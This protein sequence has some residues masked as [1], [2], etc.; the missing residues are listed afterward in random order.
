VRIALL[1]CG[2]MGSWLATL[3]SNEHEVAVFDSHPERIPKIKNVSSLK[4]LQDI[5]TFFPEMLLN[6]VSLQNTVPAFESALPFLPKECLICDV[7]SVKQGLEEYYAKSGFR[8]CSVHPMFG[9]TFANLGMLEGENAVIIIESDKKGMDFFRKIF[10]K[11]EL[12]IYDYS[13][14]EHDQMMAYSL[15]TPFVSSL[16]FTACLDRTIVPG[17]TFG[18]HL[19]IARGLLSE[20]DSLLAEIL[21]NESSVP[22]I[23]KINSKLEHL[24]H[25]IMAKDQDEIKLFLDKLRSNVGQTDSNEKGVSS[26]KKR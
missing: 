7:A 22:Q 11:L 4:S 14:K 6:A 12:N 17:S 15:T 5:K 10:T 16:V 23:N 20:D 19:K 26:K 18:K 21:F 24:K 8:F 13:F 3:L 2:K 9:P 1:G 25:I